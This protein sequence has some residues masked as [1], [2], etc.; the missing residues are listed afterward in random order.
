[1]KLQ[2][3]SFECAGVSHQGQVVHPGGGDRPAVLV[4][5][6]WSGLNDFAI[7][8][9][10][11]MA[12]RGYVGCA[13]DLFG[14]GKTGSTTEEKMGLITPL[15]KDRGL[16]QQRLL[17][18]LEKIKGL[19][20]VDAGKI[21]ALGFCFGGLCV[22]DLAR[23]GVEF[24]GALSFHG[25]LDPS[26]LTAKPIKTPVMALHGHED[27]MVDPEKVSAFEK[28]MTAAGADWQ[29]HVYGN[30]LHAFTNPQA[31]DHQLGTVYNEK[32]AARAWKLGFQF[33]DEVL[34]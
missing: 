12:E 1:M 25:L 33:L 32:T 15:I 10:K 7:N 4:A 23:S 26:G 27:P 6:D 5:H 18:A 3:F 34:S 21:A 2:E 29:L 13:V 8:A 28:E 24:K 30:T 9:A 31:N 22:L 14:E 20:G 19:D 11:K 17:S 16:L